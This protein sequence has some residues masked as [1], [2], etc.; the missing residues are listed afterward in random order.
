MERSACALRSQQGVI[1]CNSP[2]VDCAAIHLFDP[3]S[4]FGFSGVKNAHRGIPLE[5][6]WFDEARVVECEEAVGLAREE[7]EA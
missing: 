7:E 4:Q 6:P 3:I 2:R 5:C 1:D